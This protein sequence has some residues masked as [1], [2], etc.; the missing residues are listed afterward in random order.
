MNIVQ[1]TISK[2]HRIEKES[3]E[4]TGMNTISVR[5]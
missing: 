2:M 1:F 4:D 5:K 3:V